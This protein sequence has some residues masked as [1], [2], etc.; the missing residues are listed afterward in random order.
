MGKRKTRKSSS[1]GRARCRNR[2]GVLDLVWREPLMFAKVENANGVTKSCQNPPD[3][4]HYSLVD[5][6]RF[7]G[8]DVC[9]T[10]HG[11]L[12]NSRVDV[13]DFPSAQ[14]T[15][16]TAIG[17]AREIIQSHSLQ[18]VHVRVHLGRQ[19]SQSLLLGPVRFAIRS[20]EQGERRSVHPENLAVILSHLHHQLGG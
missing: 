7:C 1:D 9:R 12:V 19:M 5:T 15:L 3:G 10:S 2:S 4:H 18:L 11:P 17:T 8:W 20:N 13:R 14:P 16:Y 6:R